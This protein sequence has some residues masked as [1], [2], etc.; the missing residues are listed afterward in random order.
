MREERIVADVFDYGAE[1]YC[2]RFNTVFDEFLANFEKKRIL[3]EFTDTKGLL[4]D[5]GSGWGRYAI[6]LTKMGLDV[7]GM[8]ISRKML[9]TAMFRRERKTKHYLVQAEALQLPFKDNTFD[10]VLFVRSLKYIKDYFGVLDEVSRVLRCKGKLVIYEVGNTHTV[11]YLHHHVYSLVIKNKKTE[12]PLPYYKFSVFSLKKYLRD[13]GFRDFKVN[14][15][16]HVPRRF[17][18]KTSHEKC[19]KAIFKTEEIIDKIL[20]S[21]I[22]GYA[23]ILSAI[24]E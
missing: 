10:D 15:Y 18:K 14:G 3:R 2:L 13:M 7:V 8:D 6:E 21:A 1:N 11:N 4:L 22:F 16:L 12:D 24:K 17:Y 23:F 9:E 20:P 19:L 5:V